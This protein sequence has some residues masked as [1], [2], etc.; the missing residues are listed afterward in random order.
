MI[1]DFVSENAVHLQKI[2]LIVIFAIKKLSDFISPFGGIVLCHNILKSQLV[3]K[4]IGQ[5]FSYEQYENRCLT[6]EAVSLRRLVS[7]HLLP[8]T[9]DSSR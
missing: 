5:K 1:S 8:P 6:G 7:L 9:W 2:H 3:E 4:K